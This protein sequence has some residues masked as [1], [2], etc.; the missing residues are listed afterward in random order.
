S[1]AERSG[2]ISTIR[3]KGL[4]Y[5]YDAPAYLF[6]GTWNSYNGML[7]V[8]RVSD[9]LSFTADG[10]VRHLSVSLPVTEGEHVGVWSQGGSFS[11]LRAVWRFSLTGSTIIASSSGLSSLMVGAQV[12]LNNTQTGRSPSF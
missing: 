12:A 8:T 5:S 6:T 11:D 1:P 3:Y 7:S 2:I 9:L 10:S 4:S